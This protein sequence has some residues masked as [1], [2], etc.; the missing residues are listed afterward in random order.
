M[1]TMQFFSADD[2]LKHRTRAAPDDPVTIHVDDTIRDAMEVMLEREFDQLPVVSDRGVEGA[3][4]FKSIAKYVKSM[5]EPRVGET[6]VAVAIDRNP[7]FVD[8]DRDIFELFDTFAADDF[9]LIG[10][11]DGV[12]GLLTQYDI[13]HFLEY[14]V[15]P[16]LKIGEIEECLRRL[17]RAVDDL[18]DRIEETFADRTEYDSGYDPPE[19]V[20]NFTFDE[21]RMFVGRNLDGLP[22]RLARERGTV[23]RLLE[24]VRDIRNALFHFRASADEVD[25]DKL[26]IAHG[27]FTSLP[28]TESQR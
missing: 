27:Y 3:I 1:A 4:T 2:V 23:E 8:P 12:D 24:D 11:P 20:E 21:Y 19:R 15:E 26:D 14:Q 10:D 17:I 22:D 13:F 7:A 28:G 6:S 16:I 5:D 25:R 18:D 9:V